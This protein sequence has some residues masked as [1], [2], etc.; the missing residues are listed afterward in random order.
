A[1]RGSGTA[2][3][4]RGRSYRRRF[5]YHT[6]GCRAV[7]S[8][9]AG[10]S[11]MKRLS[12]IYLRGMAMGAADV[13]PGVSGGTIALIT[14]IYEQLITTLSGLKPSLLGVWRRQGFLAFWQASNLGFLV[15]LL[16]GI[17]TSIALL[18]RLI[19]WLMDAYPV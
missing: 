14:G 4:D 17:V 16:A 9:S 1:C 3:A 19:T 2:V 8:L 10:Y 13:V 18:A 6:A 15:A 12:G 11:Q 7:C 5:P